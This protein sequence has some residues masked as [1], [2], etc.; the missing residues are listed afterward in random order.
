MDWGVIQENWVA[1]F[2]GDML[3][4]IKMIAGECLSSLQTR[5]G[6]QE[7]SADVLEGGGMG[8]RVIHF[9]ALGNLKQ[10]DY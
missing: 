6:R 8:C 3:F 2:F 1:S 10:H 5:E 4:Q 9:S 7:G